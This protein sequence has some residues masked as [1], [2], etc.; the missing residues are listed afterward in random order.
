MADEALKRVL[1]TAGVLGA[2]TQPY[3]GR[4]KEM[5]AESAAHNS[6]L[7]VVGGTSVI[8]GKVDLVRACGHVR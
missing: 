3:I 7:F 5:A 1:K 6:N 8:G 4:L 2:F